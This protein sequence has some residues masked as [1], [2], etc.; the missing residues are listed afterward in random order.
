MRS[1]CRTDITTLH[2]K[3]ERELNTTILR[4]QNFAVYARRLT[5]LIVIV[6][7]RGGPRELRALAD[8]KEQ[9][10]KQPQNA[11][12]VRQAT[13]L[14][15]IA[16]ELELEGVVSD[17]PAT[18]DDEKLK[19][20][21][22]L[23][24]K[25]KQAQARAEQLNSAI[26]TL[27]VSLK[28]SSALTSTDT[29][30]VSQGSNPSPGPQP[31]PQVVLA[32]GYQFQLTSSPGLNT[33][34][35]I[36]PNGSNLKINFP[37][38]IA[39]GETF[40]G[41]VQTEIAGKDAKLRARNQAEIDKSVLLVG[42]EQVRAAETIFTRSI[43]PQYNAAEP[44]VVLKV[45]GKEVIRVQLPVSQTPAPSP[46]H[47]Q[48]PTCGQIGRNIVL[49][50]RSDGIIAPTDYGSIDG[51]LLQPLAKST[52]MSV[53]ENSSHVAGVTELKYREQGRQ[54]SNLFVNLGVVLTSPNTSLR[55]GQTTNMDLVVSAPGIQQDVL[56]DLVNDTP[57]IVTI[58]G[59]DRQ[60]FTIHPADVQAD[61][62]Y[63]QTFTV[64]AKSAG[65]WGATATVT[66]AGQGAVR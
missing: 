58:G 49:M 32:H 5:Q 6:R 31:S 51:T 23:E 18:A 53:M 37:N 66:C 9:R 52:S 65:A 36:F 15:D 55:P 14:R 63:R 60:H 19:S 20:L 13:Q 21:T 59:S 12:L 57:G 40:S 28:N 27:R 1:V 8:E 38:N 11:D 61:G 4:Q 41:T 45:K 25:A 17:D 7:T 24:D 35:L 30:N 39:V 64:I 34:S 62:T 33:H 2:K 3:S 22:H 50:N 46:A 29:S 48:L 42:G 44:F 26:E 54:F 10:A 16:Q 56:L 43:P 47:A